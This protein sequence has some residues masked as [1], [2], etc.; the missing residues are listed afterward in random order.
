MEKHN[1][2]EDDEIQDSVNALHQIPLAGCGMDET[3]GSEDKM[4]NSVDNPNC[5]SPDE[6][7]QKEWAEERE[8]W[9]LL[10][11]QS[12]EAAHGDNEPESAADMLIEVNPDYEGT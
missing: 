10:S 8:F 5:V 6:Q 1:L 2:S 9:Y 4:E 7:A 3:A 12:F 11:A